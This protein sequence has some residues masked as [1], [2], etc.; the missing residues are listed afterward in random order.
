MR[1]AKSVTRIAIGEP[2]RSIIR[3]D[4][5]P[6]SAIARPAVANFIDLG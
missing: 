5:G 1:D 6:F 4:G 2:A 3:I